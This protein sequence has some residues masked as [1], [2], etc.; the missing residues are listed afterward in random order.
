MKMLPI[1]VN[2]WFEGFVRNTAG[3]HCLYSPPYK[4]NYDS[5]VAPFKSALSSVIA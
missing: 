1:I 3:Y 5:T 2:R 4:R